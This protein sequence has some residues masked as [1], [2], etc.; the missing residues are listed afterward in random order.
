MFGFFLFI[1][2]INGGVD[3]DVL[4]VFWKGLGG[5]CFGDVVCCNEL[6]FGWF[7]VGVY[8]VFVNVLVMF[9]FKSCIC[10]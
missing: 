6:C 8:Y 1:G 4:Y 9:F 10:I 3:L 7:W 2:F 5:E